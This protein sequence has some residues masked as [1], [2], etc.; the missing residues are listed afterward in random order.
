MSIDIFRFYV[1]LYKY[2]FNTLVFLL[3]A[4]KKLHQTPVIHCLT[5]GI[6]RPTLL[7]VRRA[8]FDFNYFT[9]RFT[10]RPGT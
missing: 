1:K 5:K 7:C 6:A 10:R 8:V 3:S 9:T 4:D 2:F